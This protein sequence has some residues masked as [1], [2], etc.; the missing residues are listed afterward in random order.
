LRADEEGKMKMKWALSLTLIVGLVGSA[1]PV[2]AQEQ[3]VPDGSK[4]EIAGG[5]SFLQ[6]LNS[7]Q[8][9]PKGFFVSVDRNYNGWFGLTGSIDSAVGATPERGAVHPIHGEPAVVY[10]IHRPVG[11]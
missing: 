3:T 7:H 6:D 10:G 2:A 1:L 8:S 9:V 5:Y 4:Y 11:E